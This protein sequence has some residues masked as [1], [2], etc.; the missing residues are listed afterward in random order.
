MKLR[1]QIFMKR[2]QM[3][4]GASHPEQHL[5]P[6]EGGR[7]RSEKEMTPYKRPFVPLFNI[8]TH[9]APSRVTRGSGRGFAVVGR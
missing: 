1:V 6:A 9:S 8:T 7:G 3:L 5:R 2:L 4:P